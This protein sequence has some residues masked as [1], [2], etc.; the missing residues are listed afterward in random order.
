MAEQATLALS[1][2]QAGM[3]W[4]TAPTGYVVDHNRVRLGYGQAIF[5]Q[6]CRLLQSWRMVDLGWLQIHPAAPK[7]QTGMNV[8][9]LATVGG[10]W[11]LNACRFQFPT[12]AEAAQ[13]L[14]RRWQEA[15]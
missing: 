5:E 6:A 7:I 10:F 1:Y 2:P 13:D 11:F 14:C 3:T 12:W 9:L 4:H 8:A 15:R